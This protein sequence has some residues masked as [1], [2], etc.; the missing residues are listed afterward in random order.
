MKRFSIVAIGIVFLLTGLYTQGF[1]DSDHGSS[2]RLADPAKK[3]AISALSIRIEDHIVEI[4][5]TPSSSAPNNQPAEKY[6]YAGERIAF[7][8]TIFLNIPGVFY[9]YTILTDVGGKVVLLDN[10]GYQS[11][12]SYYDFWFS[13]DTMPRGTYNF[14][15]LIS[16]ANGLLL[17]PTAFTFTVL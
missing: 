15:I 17:S 4:Y 10:Y 12:K 7:V 2:A 13:T 9:V 16:T 5:T 8:G 6:F 11:L 1:A 3:D 14:S